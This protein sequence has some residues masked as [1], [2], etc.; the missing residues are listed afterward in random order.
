MPQTR[1]WLEAGAVS[2]D[3]ERVPAS[4]RRDLACNLT[5]RALARTLEKLESVN[6]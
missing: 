1:A 2:D 6:V 5:L 3:D 4:Y